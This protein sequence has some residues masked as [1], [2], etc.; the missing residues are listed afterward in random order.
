MSIIFFFLFFSGNSIVDIRPLSKILPITKLKW[1]YLN[2]NK[3]GDPGIR[4]LCKCLPDTKITHLH[5][6][7]KFVTL[8]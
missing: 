8:I 6:N 7:G 1:L 3:F 2:T 5:L 4:Y